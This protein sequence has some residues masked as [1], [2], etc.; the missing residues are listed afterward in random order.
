M[1]RT[2]RSHAHHRIGRALADPVVAFHRRH[3]QIR[4][5]AVAR[6]QQR[7]GRHALADG[8]G[9]TGVGPAKPAAAGARRR[10]RLDVHRRFHDHAGDFGVVG[11]RRSQARHAGARTLRGAADDHHPGRAV[12]GTEQRHRARRLGIRA[13]HG[14]LVRDAGGHGP[15]PYQGR[16]HGLDGD[17]SAGTRSSS[18][19]PTAPSG[20]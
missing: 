8:A 17:Q 13:G 7:R 14:G 6:R 20:W 10:R 16:S 3:R 9:A 11:G 5:A 19:C 12:L 2:G 18:C 15:G 1:R 4:P